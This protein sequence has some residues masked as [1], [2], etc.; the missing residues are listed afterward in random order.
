M[1][2]SKPPA[3]S[4]S[5][6]GSGAPK[7][8][9]DAQRPSLLTRLLSNKKR[10]MM[11]LGIVIKLSL[12]LS[13][14]YRRHELE[15]VRFLAAAPP[16]FCEARS[17]ERPRVCAHSGDWDSPAPDSAP[18]LRDA[19]AAGTGC[20]LVH[21]A[22][23]A[24]GQLVAIRN[25]VEALRLLTAPPAG[26]LLAA[27]VAETS[28]SAHAWRKVATV[29]DVS[30]DELR[31]SLRWRRTRSRRG[32]RRA[33]LRGE[34]QEEEDDKRVLT[35]A[36]ALSLLLRKDAPSTTTTIIVDLERPT[37]AARARVPLADL[38]RRAVEAA[39]DAGCAPDQCLF[40]A[41][42]DLVVEAAAAAV[43]AEGGAA[44]GAEAGAG[45]AEAEKGKGQESRKTK[46]AVG[47]FV[48]E[49]RDPRHPRLKGVASAAAV[50]YSMLGPAGAA[51][52]GGRAVVRALRDAK[53]D[54]YAYVVNRAAPLRAAAV[55]GVRAVVTDRP[56]Q[57]AGVFQAWE[58]HCALAE[59]AAAGA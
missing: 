45:A 12:V 53:Q 15:L 13:V 30:L 4:S 39:R 58:R 1:Y 23:T 44:A 42:D 50:H 33:R 59:G 21:A 34:G 11:S 10:A 47:Y 38:A 29:G 57:V 43:V 32:R 18:A 37:G 7:R 3:S 40:W 6:A 27:R 9:F 52:G 54:A 24:D 8:V 35:L 17:G 48:A 16:A 14:V 22:A 51:S 28:R 55:A 31:G 49:R 36:E 46:Y 25:T 19:L 56:T 26:S 5:G 20:V 41:M 2:L